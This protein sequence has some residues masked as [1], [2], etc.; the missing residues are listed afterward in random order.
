MTAGSR[1]NPV[2]GLLG[3]IAKAG[4]TVASAGG[5]L[6][7]RPRR[8]LTPEL[9]ERI[10]ACRHELL[11]FLRPPELPQ[12][13]RTERW[14]GPEALAG[15]PRGV[16]ELAGPRPGWTPLSWAGRLRQLAGRCEGL[17]PD[18][19]DVL[20]QAAGVIER[21]CRGGSGA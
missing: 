21:V 5:Q 13:V 8:R 10:R 2:A 17:H 9:A 11:E 18:R 20:R 12:D 3:E 1:Y 14:P 7:V 16:A 19:A 6:L 15:L 4:L